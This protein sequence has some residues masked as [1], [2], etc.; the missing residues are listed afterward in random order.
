ME[1]ENWQK[2]RHIDALA[3][4]LHGERSAADAFTFRSLHDHV[5]EVRSLKDRHDEHW[6]AEAVDCIIH[7]LVLLARH[8]VGQEVYGGLLSRRLERFEEKINMALKTR[9]A[10]Q[11]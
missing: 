2:V 6:K 4:R 1:A 11:S 3:L 8:G 9:G 10:Q 7:N 5:E